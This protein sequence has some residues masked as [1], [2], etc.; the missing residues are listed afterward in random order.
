MITQGSLEAGRFIAAY[1]SNGRT[2]AAVSFN[3]GKWLD[4][5]QRMIEQAA[6][7]PPTVAVVDPSQPN[8]PE[9]AGFPDHSQMDE[10]TALLTG[11]D[12]T[13]RQVEWVFEKRAH[14]ANKL[15]NRHE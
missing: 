11:Y 2:L 10:A 9:P 6:P 1:G 13:D 8:D 12:A 3:C 5:Y 14:A 15:T 4:A 7:F